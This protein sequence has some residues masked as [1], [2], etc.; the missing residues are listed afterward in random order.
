MAVELEAEILRGGAH[1]GEVAGEFGQARLAV[2]PHRF[3]EV[4]RRAGSGHEIPL[5]QALGP[6]LCHLAVDDK[7]RAKPDPCSAGVA[8]AKLEGAD[9][10]VERGVAIGVE[11][12]HRPGVGAARFGLEPAQRGDRGNLGRAGDRSARKQC[13]DDVDRVEAR[14]EGGGDVGHHL[15][16]RGIGFDREQAGHGDAAGL[17]DAGQVVAEEVDDHEVFGALLGVGGEGVGGGAVRGLV[18]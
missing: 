2:E 10:D 15:V 4:E 3:N 13:L 16:E 1:P 14:A 7:P 8:V 18:G 17:G 12:A 11:P 6:F 9:E 5:E